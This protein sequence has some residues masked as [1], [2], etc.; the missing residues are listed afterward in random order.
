[1]I[2]VICQ[3]GMPPVAM[4]WTWVGVLAGPPPCGGAR[5][6]FAARTGEKNIHQEQVPLLRP[7][8]GGIERQ[9]SAEI[10]DAGPSATLHHRF[11]SPG[12]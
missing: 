3:P 12:R 10:G 8:G 5:D 2:R 1:M 11:P 9:R 7:I 4:R 6:Q